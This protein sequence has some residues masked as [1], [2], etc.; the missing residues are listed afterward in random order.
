[1]KGLTSRGLGSKRLRTQ[2]LVSKWMR[3]Y[4]R[5]NVPKLSTEELREQ[6]RVSRQRVRRRGNA[7]AQAIHR[8]ALEQSSAELKKRMA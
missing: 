6:I 1:M 5:E 4:I 8:E 2:P 3:D 7:E